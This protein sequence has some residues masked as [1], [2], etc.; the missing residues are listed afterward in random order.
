MTLRHEVAAVLA[1]TQHALLTPTSPAFIDP[2]LHEEDLVTRRWLWTAALQVGKQVRPVLKTP[3]DQRVEQLRPRLTADEA[4]AFD[5]GT[6]IENQL[7]LDDEALASEISKLISRYFWEPLKD[8]S[9]LKRAT[10]PTFK[11]M[12]AI[13]QPHMSEDYY[14]HSACSVTS[15]YEAA[16]RIDGARLAVL[17]QIR[18]LMPDAHIDVAK[19]VYTLVEVSIDYDH[20]DGLV[21]KPEGEREPKVTEKPFPEQLFEEVIRITV[22]RDGIT[23]SRDYVLPPLKPA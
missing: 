11:K 7:Y 9:A 21:L 8:I 2:T 17:D 23:A 22:Q 3:L 19:K 16:G 13:N 12:L 20:G 1:E 5:N 18:Q 14:N 15:S 4:R 6:L 10:K